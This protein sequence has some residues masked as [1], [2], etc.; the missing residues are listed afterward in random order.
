[1]ESKTIQ[2]PWSK[3]FTWEDISTLAICLA[4]DLLDLLVPFMTTPIYG[5]ILDFS[6]IGF[7]V[8]FFNWIGAIT[9]VEL[10]PGLDI[11]PFYTIAW[12][13]WYINHRRVRRKQLYEELESWK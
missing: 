7:C 5:D 3:L 1:M 4:L 10:I 13:T 2:T 9:I 12:L 6:G 11:V 8:L